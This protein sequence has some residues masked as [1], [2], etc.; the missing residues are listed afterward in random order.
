MGCYSAIIDDDNEVG[1]L[2]EY[3]H[4]L[5]PS[6]LPP[7]KLVLKKRIP[8]ILLR[9]L[10]PYRGLCNGTRLFVVNMYDGRV[11]EA[12]IID[13]QVDGQVILIPR[14]ACHPKDGDFPFAWRLASISG[15]L[16]LCHDHQ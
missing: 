5:M 16:L 12:V 2:A 15:A 3:L 8:V 14:I 9:N 13:G 7:H 1:V 11:L 6:G 4:T 10:N